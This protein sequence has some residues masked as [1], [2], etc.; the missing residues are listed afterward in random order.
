[1][2]GEAGIVLALSAGAV[3]A[4]TFGYLRPRGVFRGA[5]LLVAFALVFPFAVALLAGP[6]LG[7]GA[8]LGVALILYAVSALVM[9]AALFAAIGAGLRLGLKSRR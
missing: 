4:T 6:F 8:G 5:A 3:S 2:S 9:A 1:M 7:S